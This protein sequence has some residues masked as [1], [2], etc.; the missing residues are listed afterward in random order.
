LIDLSAGRVQ[1]PVRTVIPVSEHN[2]WLGVMPAVYRGVCGAKLVTFYPGNGTR[3]IPTHMAIILLFRAE[4]GEPIAVF[5]ARLITEMRT[6]AVSAVATEALSP[7]GARVLAVLGSGVQCRSH[8]EA[9]RTVRTFDEIRVWSPDA[10]RCRACAEEVGAIAALSA[11]SAV[12]DADVVVTVTS[13][14]EPVL[15]GKLLKPGAYVNAV[16]AVGPRRRELDG[17]AMQASVIVE[18]R[19]A[20]LTESGDIL[21]AG[22]SIAAELGD[23]LAGKFV[24]PMGRRVVFKSLGVAVEDLAA[25]LLVLPKI[26][27]DG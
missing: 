13:A 9:F 24:P 17:D 26:H 18:S 11:E 6:A 27:V 5:D 22:A 21:M 3:G 1:Q 16:G 23:V 19:E 8:I 14:A 25:A 12:R 4:T 7:A 20:A 10:A 15:Q 2:G